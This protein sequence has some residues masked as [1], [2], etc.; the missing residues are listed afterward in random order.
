MRAAGESQRARETIPRI[1]HQTWKTEH[2]PAR[3]REARRSWLAAHPGWEHRFWTDEDLDRLVRSRAPGFYPLWRAYPWDIQR[4]DSARYLMLHEIGGVYADLDLICLKPLDDLLG[5]DLVLA[6]T[7]PLG[8]TNALMMSRP[9]HP[10]MKSAVERLP[11]A[12]ERWQRTL[13]PRHFRV[14]LT[15]GPLFISG[16]RRALGVRQGSSAEMRLMRERILGLDEYGHAAAERSYVRHIQGGSWEGWDS[17]LFNF[18]Y[19]YWA[20]VAGTGAA[21]G[22]A[23]LS[24]ME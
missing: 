18:A 17:K 16:C 14:L 24:L 11:D 6:R 9:G 21:A 10:L 4:V 1:L 13:L 7:R 19:E 2:V 23:I 5:H 8:L 15:T 22:A 12:F 20:V 3:W